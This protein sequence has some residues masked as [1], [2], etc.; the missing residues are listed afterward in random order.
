MIREQVGVIC[1]EDRIGH[2]GTGS[3]EIADFFTP[4]GTGTDH[5]A[6]NGRRAVTCIDLRAIPTNTKAGYR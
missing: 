2:T 4:R 3:T 6:G 5:P 1:G